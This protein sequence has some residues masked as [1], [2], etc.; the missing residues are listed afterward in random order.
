MGP[1]TNDLP[2]FEDYFQVLF[3]L[4]SKLQSRD[5]VAVLDAQVVVNQLDG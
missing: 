2:P 4:I 3:T 5:S 1:V